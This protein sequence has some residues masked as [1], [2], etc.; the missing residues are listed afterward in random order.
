MKSLHMVAWILVIVGGL[1]WLLI[2]LGGFAG[3]DWNVVHL[4][5]GSWPAL[6]WIVYILVGISAVYEIVTHKKNCAVCM[7]SSKPAM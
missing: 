7:A 4:I 6:E 1:N 2:G 3:A 5:L